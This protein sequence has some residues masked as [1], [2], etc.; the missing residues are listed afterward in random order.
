MAFG[1]KR[2]N[3]KNNQTTLGTYTVTVT[4]GAATECDTCCLPHPVMYSFQDGSTI[5][6]ICKNGLS[7]Q[8]YMLMAISG[9]GGLYHMGGDW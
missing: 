6:E 7:D 5:C 2:S 4:R 9:M 8:D 1:K 3:P